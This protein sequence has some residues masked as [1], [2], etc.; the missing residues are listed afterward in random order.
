MFFCFIT[1]IKLNRIQHMDVS[2]NSPSS[3]STFMSVSSK[4]RNFQP[5][6]CLHL[7]NFR[8]EE[9]LVTFFLIF[10]DQIVGEI[11]L[12]QPSIT[13][14]HVGF[15]SVKSFLCDEIFQI[16]DVFSNHEVLL[17]HFISQIF[18]KKSP[19]FK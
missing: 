17:S 11:L 3:F 15:F 16:L 9:I 4:N 18:D 13:R 7:G 5:D 6:E 12:K 19:F 2:I 1:N 10:F 8:H 14:I